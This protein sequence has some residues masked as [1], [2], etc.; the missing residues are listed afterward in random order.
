MTNRYLE[1]IAEKKKGE[2]RDLASSAIGG[3]GGGAIGYATGSTLG[4]RR[5]SKLRDLANRLDAT[6][7]HNEVVSKRAGGLGSEVPARQREMAMKTRKKA[8]SL[9]KKYSRTGGALGAGLGL[10][11]AYALSKY[12]NRDKKK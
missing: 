12:L 11:S 5:S 6:A 4:E 7:A 10:T 9:S 3:I 2:S 8:K 1:K